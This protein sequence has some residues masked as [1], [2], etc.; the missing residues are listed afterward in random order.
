MV[1]YG[2]EPFPPRPPRTVR[3][4]T[5]P[6]IAAERQQPAPGSA[7]KVELLGTFAGPTGAWAALQDLMAAVP[8]VFRLPPM[9][10]GPPAYRRASR[11]RRH[12][13]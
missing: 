7:V 12:R 8:P 3:L 1:R 5:A 4:P 6:A 2:T 13:D 10:G 9:E 11:R